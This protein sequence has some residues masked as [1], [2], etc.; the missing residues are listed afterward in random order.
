MIVRDNARTIGAA[1]ESARPWIDE[2][3]VVD[4]GSLDETRAICRNP[5]AQV[6]F[7]PWIDDFAAA[8]NESLRHAQGSWFFWM[9]S[10]D[11]LPAE[12]GRQLRE[13]AL[14]PNPDNVLGFVMQVHCP[15]P[16]GTDGGD[17]TVVDHV[18]LRSGQ[19]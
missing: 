11:T 17:M 15:G 5:G 13:L 10:D 2:L 4:T 19:G 18:K 3:I 6:Q 16:E 7:F 12:C 1:L 8:R 14:A 9:D